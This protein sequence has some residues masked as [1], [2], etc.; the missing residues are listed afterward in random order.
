MPIAAI[1]TSRQ[2]RFWFSLSLTFAVIYGLLGLQEAFSSDYVV[3]DDARQHVFWMQRFLDPALF[4]NDLIANYFQSVAP[5]GYTAVYQV[6]AG[7]GINPLILNKLLPTVLGLLTT[8]YCF[9]VCLELLP[10]PIAG[11]ITTLLL[12]QSLW[13]KDDLVSATPRA[14]VYPLF[15]AFLFYLLRRSLLLVCV[16]IALLGL[17]YPHFVFIAAIILILRLLHW[18]K[19]LPR[20]SQNQSDYWFCA[21]GLGVAV[22]IMLPF[23]LEASEFGPTITAAEARKLPEFLPQGRSAFFYDDPWRFWLSA[24]R[25]GLLP[26]IKPPLLAAGFLLP[27]LLRYPSHFPL[28]QQVSNKVAILPQIVVASCVMFFGAHALLFKLHLPNRYSEH[29]LKIVL[30]ISAGITLVVISDALW[31]TAPRFLP[32]FQRQRLLAL[33]LVA[34]LGAA[35]VLY[36]SFEEFPV[37]KYKVGSF[38]LLYK[39]FQEQPKNSLIASLS[40]EADNIPTFSGRSILVGREYAIPYNL[41]YYSQFR[42]RMLAVIRAQ[43]SLD[44]TAVQ[45]LIQKYGVDF[46]LL[47]RTAFI[48]EYVANNNWLTQY[49][50]A[51]TEALTKLHQGKL[52]ALSGVIERCSVF[53]T[54]GLVVLDAACIAISN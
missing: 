51:A 38:P 25:S 6:M 19:G 27:V 23:A 20:L 34:L 42:Q 32:H 17:F 54:P 16:T 21:I 22:L 48:P 39:F 1:T 46:W 18:E 10:V 53:E 50:P 40:T 3:Q 43:Y 13:M 36:P 41:G 35:L 30:A 11:F 15:L 49:Q 28:R 47:D 9:G 8:G 12:N 14:F 44:L 2:V 4:P 29:S 31:H 33:A 45:T 24:S 7:L 37:T 5:A 26:S 52:P